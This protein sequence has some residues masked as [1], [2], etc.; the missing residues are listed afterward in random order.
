[1]SC[2]KRVYVSADGLLVGHL[3][4]V[5]EQHHIPCM[6]K[7]M[8]LQ[9][10]VGELPPHECWPELWVSDAADYEL[11]RRLIA[12]VLGT[13]SSASP[14]GCAQCAEQIEGQFVQCWN[15]C[16]VAEASGPLS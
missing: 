15:C 10:A 9:G 2:M 12:N 3:Q 1:M 5:L 8:Y 11:A 14:W 6:V 13:D 4:A 16:H 7:N